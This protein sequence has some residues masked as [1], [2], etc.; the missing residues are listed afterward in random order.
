MIA[1]IFLSLAPSRYCLLVIRG[2][3]AGTVVVEGGTHQLLT[4][5]SNLSQIRLKSINLLCFSNHPVCHF[6]SLLIIC[7]F[8]LI[9]PPSLQ[10]LLSTWSHLK[11]NKWSTENIQRKAK[12]NILHIWRSPSHCPKAAKVIIWIFLFQLGEW[13]RSQDI[14]QI[15][16]RSMHYAVGSPS[17]LWAVKWTVQIAH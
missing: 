6:P 8:L 9:P 4:D 3:H 11:W 5:A 17:N 13:M 10:Q 1:C 12:L 16:V 15:F 14:K 2:C 7:E